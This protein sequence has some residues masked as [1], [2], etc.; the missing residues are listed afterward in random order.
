MF[1][2]L[3]E[4]GVYPGLGAEVRELSRKLEW[5]E[6]L[7]CWVRYEEVIPRARELGWE[8]DDSE[9]QMYQNGPLFRRNT[10]CGGYTLIWKCRDFWQCTDYLMCDDGFVRAQNHRPWNFI[11][12]LLEREGKVCQ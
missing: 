11:N 1:F 8:V 5:G 10:K 2:T 9:G 12:D 3:E 7:T 6:D 4:H